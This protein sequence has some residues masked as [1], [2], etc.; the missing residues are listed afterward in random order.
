MQSL[1]SSVDGLIQELY[2]LDAQERTGDMISEKY[3]AVRN[4]IVNVIQTINATTEKVSEK[5]KKIAMYK[6]MIYVSY[7]DL[8]AS[9]Q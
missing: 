2:D 7:Q 5:L 4:E 9:R 8:Q 3:R 6:K 1:Q